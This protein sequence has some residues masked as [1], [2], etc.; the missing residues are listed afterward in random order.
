M[1]EIKFEDLKVKRIKELIIPEPFKEVVQLVSDLVN[2][3]LDDFSIYKMFNFIKS[4]SINISCVLF[5]LSSLIDLNTDRTPFYL[6][7]CKLINHPRKL[8]PSIFHI[9]G[10][11]EV[12]K[13]DRLADLVIEIEEKS[14]D[15]NK[16]YDL[17]EYACKYGSENC[18]AYLKHKITKISEHSFTTAI[19]GG[20]KNIINSIYNDC[21][22]EITRLHLETALKYHQ[23]DIFDWLLEKRGS[24]PE[25]NPTEFIQYGNL[26]AF[27]FLIENGFNIDDHADNIIC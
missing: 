14:Y 26:K 24:I 4:S 3:E 9:N 12:I 16:L 7:I 15:E 21:V 10:I 25:F 1:A 17:F 23:N 27:V 2:D 8:D 22:T 13:Y 11:E 18:F 6:E 20:N 5:I 19:R